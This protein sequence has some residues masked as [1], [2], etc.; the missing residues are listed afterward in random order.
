MAGTGGSNH[1]PWTVT[2]PNSLVRNN[3]TFGVLKLTLHA[4]SYDWQF[5]PVS[6][7]FKILGTA[8]CH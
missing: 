6:G 5:L 8:A 4:A 2:Q 3:T 7:T 1:T